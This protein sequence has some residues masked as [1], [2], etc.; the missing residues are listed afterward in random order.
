MDK[1]SVK[2]ELFV[3]TKFVYLAGHFLLLHRNIKQIMQSKE[4]V[5]YCVATL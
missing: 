4:L 1:Q 5:T 3:S 2:L